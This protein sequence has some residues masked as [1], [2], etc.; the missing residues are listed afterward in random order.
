MLT[1]TVGSE[2]LPIQLADYQRKCWQRRLKNY[3]CT[4]VVRCK[5]GERLYLCPTAY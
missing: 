2:M 5:I 3:R 1:I 4:E